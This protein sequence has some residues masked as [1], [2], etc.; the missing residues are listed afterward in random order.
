MSA[1]MSER[2]SVLRDEA[3][4]C[5]EFGENAPG[6]EIFDAILTRLA[7]L[8]ETDPGLDLSLQDG[9]SRRLAWGESPA[10]I[11]VDCDLVCKRLIAAVQ[12]S[13]PDPSEAIVVFAIITDVACTSSRHIARMAVQRSS[14]ERALE[15]RELMVQRQ[16]SAALEHQED[17]IRKLQA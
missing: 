1:D 14:S 16:L 4:N 5:A 13:F 2:L 3:L 6:A 11:I 8:G 9:L 15:R 12:R 7:H 10:T 17:L